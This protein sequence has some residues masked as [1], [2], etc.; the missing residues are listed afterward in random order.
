M[1]DEPCWGQGGGS[2]LGEL[3]HAGHTDKWDRSRTAHAV[4]TNHR[5]K[6]DGVSPVLNKF[7]KK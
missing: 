1:R 6:G 3:E 4:S 2:I 7:G 5:Q